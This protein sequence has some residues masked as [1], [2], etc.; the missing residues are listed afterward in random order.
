VRTSSRDFVVV[1]F[2][3]VEL[4]DVAAVMQVASTA[5]RHWN[6]RPFRLLPAALARGPIQTRNQLTLEATSALGEQQKPELF[7][8]PGGYGARRAAAD[9]QIVRWV[10]T[11]ASSAELVLAVGSGV[12]VLGA[13]GLLSGVTVAASPQNAAWLKD[14]LPALTLDSEKPIVDSGKWLTAAT[15]ADSLEL[16]FTM[17]QRCLGRSVTRAARSALGYPQTERIE[18]SEP[19]PAPPKREPG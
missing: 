12:A 1:L 14:E 17:V 7:F 19:W 16:A 4:L 5:G 3:E 8:V 6:W 2:D 9:P 18:L 15:S 13:A 10:A 11:A